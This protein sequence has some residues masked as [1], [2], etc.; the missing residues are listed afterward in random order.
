MDHHIRIKNMFFI[1]FVLF[2]P[3]SIVVAQTSSENI[4]KK[5]ITGHLENSVTK[6]PLT[7][8]KVDLLSSDS[9][10]IDSTRTIYDEFG[11]P[12]RYS[13]F[14]FEITHPGHYLIR[15]SLP[16]YKMLYIPVNIKFHKRETEIFLGKFQ[17]QWDP[18]DRHLLKEKI[19]KATK[20]KFYHNGDTLVYNADAFQLADGS[21]LDMLIKQ[22]PGVVLKNNGQIFVNGKF[23]SSLLLN[24]MPFIV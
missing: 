22:L 19:V 4:N 11:Y 13:Y 10:F 7:D 18:Q 8:A 23:V 14:K 2:S 21:M 16:Y 15:C 1:L 20:I 3:T 12:T 24:G 9:S 5:V 6:E 17:M